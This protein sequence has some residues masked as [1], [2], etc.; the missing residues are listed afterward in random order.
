MSDDIQESGPSGWAWFQLG[1]MA[2]KA[3]RSRSDAIASVFT[4][5]RQR[6]VAPDPLVLQNQVLAAENAQL[7]QELEDYKL[8]YRNLKAWADRAEAQIDQLLKE[9]GE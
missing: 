5:R 8:N 9:R 6:T 2:A 4:A 1:R 3:D 7:R